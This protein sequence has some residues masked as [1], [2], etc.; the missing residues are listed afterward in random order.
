MQACAAVPTQTAA[1]GRS[2]SP[3]AAPPLCPE[4]NPTDRMNNKPCVR[5]RMGGGTRHGTA[6]SWL[7]Q[8]MVIHRKLVCDLFLSPLP[9][10]RS[11][12]VLQ[13]HTHTLT[14][15][16]GQSLT[17]QQSPRVKN[18]ERSGRPLCTLTQRTKRQKRWRKEKLETGSSKP[19]R[20]KSGSTGFILQTSLCLATTELRINCS[21][22]FTTCTHHTQHPCRPQTASGSQ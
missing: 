12:H 19:G 16:C 1:L 14:G 3:S 17:R 20:K 6:T 18:Q 10:N 21:E 9:V 22:T 5:G 15:K 8:F 2:D 4:K 11:H 7:Q 13:L